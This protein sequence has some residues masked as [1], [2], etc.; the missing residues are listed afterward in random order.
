[1]SLVD[2]PVAPRG[3]RERIA[4]SDRPL[5][6]LA[7]GAVNTGFGLAIFPLLLWSSR[8]LH[9]HYMIALL[10]AQACSVTFAFV[11]YRVA[12]S[13]AKGGIA[14]QFGLFSTYYLVNYLLNWG[15]LPLLVEVGGIPPIIAQ[16]GFTIVMIVG[17]Y[18]W[19]SRV[20]FG[21]GEAGR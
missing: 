19:H 21:D 16:L 12:L 10:I 20:T 8:W 3:L 4:S 14:K 17:S 13:A 18:F 7:A 1:M 15:A 11:A 9:Q 5:R 6:F 2:P